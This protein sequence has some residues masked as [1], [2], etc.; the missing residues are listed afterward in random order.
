M[1]K[2]IFT[3]AIM[4]VA[5]NHL[6]AV[7]ETYG[8]SYGS[9]F[10]N[11]ATEWNNYYEEA[12]KQRLADEER[13]TIEQEQEKRE[14]R[15]SGETNDKLSRILGA[16]SDRNKAKQES[17]I[18]KEQDQLK[19]ELAIANKRD[20]PLGDVEE[21]KLNLPRGMWDLDKEGANRILT[22]R[23]VD[24][25][26]NQAATTIQRA[27]RARQ[28]KNKEEDLSAE[29]SATTQQ[30]TLNRF[31]YLDDQDL[32]DKIYATRGEIF[33]AIQ[34]L[35]TQNDDPKVREET[36][37]AVKEGEAR[38]A[39][40]KARA[41]ARGVVTENST[42]NPYRER[43]FPGTSNRSRRPSRIWSKNK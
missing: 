23:R 2:L 6:K 7:G 15:K 27:W 36:L 14:G 31:G 30:G 41:E 35:K 21:S 12:A 28:A 43:T 17:E 42:K 11:E 8:P 37:Q 26:E 24:K 29:V 3:L 4:A 13:R 22:K 39:A 16:L 5:G 40:R 19:A 1:K 25:L 33:Q 10:I 20:L 38:R 9:T 34:N 32:Q 18:Q